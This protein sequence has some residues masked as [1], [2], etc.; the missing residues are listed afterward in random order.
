MELLIFIV[1]FM[2]ATRLLHQVRLA[3]PNNLIFLAALSI[4]IYIF[5]ISLVKALLELLASSPVL[6]L[7]GL[8]L[9]IGAVIYVLRR[10][11]YGPF[12]TY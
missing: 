6:I 1:A 4:T 8:A 9:L 12:D 3:F 11:A 7:V 10:R 2:L 5:A